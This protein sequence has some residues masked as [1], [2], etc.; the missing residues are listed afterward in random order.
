MWYR[1]T[2]KNQVIPAGKKVFLWLSR[3]DGK[4]QV[5]VNGQL[6]RYTNDKD[7]V[8]DESPAVY[9]NSLAFDITNALKSNAD[10]QITIKATRTFINELG[11]GGLTG[12][13][14]LY[15]DK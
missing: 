11:T 8:A 7:E 10:N 6:I 4:A 5:W 14:Y 2:F 1:T 13:V 9:G 3:T 15:Q 12:P